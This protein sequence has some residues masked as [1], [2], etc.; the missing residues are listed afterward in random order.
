MTHHSELFTDADFYRRLDGPLDKSWR[1]TV[2]FPH[3]LALAS[4][5]QSVA[6]G[7]CL[8]QDSTWALAEVRSPTSP[9]PSLSLLPATVGATDSSDG[10]MQPAE[11][12]R[13]LS[14]IR[15]LVADS[16][17]GAAFMAERERAREAVGQSVSWWAR[18]PP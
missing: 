16:E 13:A 18:M 3:T 1:D 2:R 6:D 4:A 11:L 5:V 8:A 14:A 9:T 15:S 7:C 17:K 12:S 10:L